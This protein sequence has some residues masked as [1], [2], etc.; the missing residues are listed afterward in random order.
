MG[1]LGI[2]FFIVV[3]SIYYG[4]ASWV[5]TLLKMG[6]AVFAIGWLGLSISLTLVGYSSYRKILEMRSAGREQYTQ[7]IVVDF[8]PY[9]LSKNSAI[10]SFKVDH[11]TFSYSPNE[12]RP[13]FRKTYAKGSP[14]QNGVN[15]RISSIED[16]ITRL[17]IC[18]SSP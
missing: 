8:S 1:A 16:S 17:E 11:R 9:D 7:G 3:R 15:V 14:I 12:I 5:G 6:S 10:E 2:A 4:R 13:G 18:Q